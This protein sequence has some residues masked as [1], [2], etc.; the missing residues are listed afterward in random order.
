MDKG[1]VWNSGPITN[2]IQ[3]SN[4]LK[5]AFENILTNT[6]SLIDTLMDVMQPP[7]MAN[8]QVEKSSKSSLKAFLGTLAY[9]ILNGISK[10]GYS[11]NGD[12]PTSEKLFDWCLAT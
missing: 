2:K 5:V 12:A 9:E 3:E 4:W 8:T 10:L 7:V 6:K 1:N 11:F